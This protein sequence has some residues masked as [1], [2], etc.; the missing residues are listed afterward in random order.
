MTEVTVWRS[1]TLKQQFV[2]LVALAEKPVG[3]PYD[4]ILL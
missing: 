3:Y 4:F 2:L 1:Q